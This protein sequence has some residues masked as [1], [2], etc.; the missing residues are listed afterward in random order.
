M[1][2]GGQHCLSFT[3]YLYFFLA[4]FGSSFSK[5]DTW[6]RTHHSVISSYSF[7][8]YPSD[9][10]STINFKQMK[11]KQLYVKDIPNPLSFYGVPSIFLLCVEKH[12]L[13]LSI[14]GSCSLFYPLASQFCDLRGK[15]EIS[16]GNKKNFY[17]IFTIPKITKLKITYKRIH[18]SLYFF[19]TKHRKFM[20]I[21]KWSR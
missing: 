6:Q 14:A 11:R 1:E 2:S 9:V 7:L 17:F 5:L 19:I 15:D 20:E 4:A 16:S 13:C 8:F 18:E 3:I 12:M 21:S 10:R